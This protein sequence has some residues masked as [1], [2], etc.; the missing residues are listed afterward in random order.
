MVAV[1]PSSPLHYQQM[2][3]LKSS[4][5]RQEY[6]FNHNFSLSKR[7]YPG[8]QHKCIHSMAGPYRSP[9][10]ILQSSQMPPCV[11]CQLSGQEHRGTLDG[12]RKDSPYQLLRVESSLSSL[13]VLNL[14][15]VA[16][17]LGMQ[18]QFYLTCPVS[19]TMR[20][21]L[22][23]TQA[24]SSYVDIPIQCRQVLRSRCAIPGLTKSR[25]SGPPLQAFYP[26]F[27]ATTY[28]VQCQ[29]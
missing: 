22:L 19:L 1:H 6:P 2:E 20:I 28:F 3:R 16:S 10:G 21:F 7:T 25:R 9:I 26:S 27:Q 23:D 13:A 15:A 12:Y 5:L 24:Q 4:Y 29:H 14:S 18:M 8:G 17:I 11:G